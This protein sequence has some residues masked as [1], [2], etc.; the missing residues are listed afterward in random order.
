MQHQHGVSPSIFLAGRSKR[1]LR[2]G[3]VG[4]D[5]GEGDQEDEIRHQ[6]AH[7]EPGKGPVVDDEIGYEDEKQSR[8][9]HDDI[10]SI[11]ALDYHWVVHLLGHLD[12]G[13][14]SF[15]ISGVL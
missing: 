15:F 7:D 1:K 14:L 2:E 9:G 4:H 6:G 5:C 8:P 12:F 3:A 11:P 13:W 10:V